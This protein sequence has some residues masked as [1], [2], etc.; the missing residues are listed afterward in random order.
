MSPLAQE[1][2]VYAT[3][4]MA[5]GWLVWRWIR[6]R[7][8]PAACERCGPADGPARPR[9]GIRPSSLKVLR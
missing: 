2:A 6:G 3:V 9:R 8:A 5:S 7:R 4:A 1:L